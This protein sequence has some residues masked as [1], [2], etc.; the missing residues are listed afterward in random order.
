MLF[1]DRGIEVE[2]G[3]GGRPLLVPWVDVTSVSVDA[4]PV[5]VGD[6]RSSRIVASIDRHQVRLTVAGDRNDDVRIAALKT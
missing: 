5:V 3:A 6:V 2:A 1:D 4:V